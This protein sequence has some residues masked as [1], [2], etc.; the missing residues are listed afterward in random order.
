MCRTLLRTLGHR[1]QSLRASGSK[2]VSHHPS[3]PV[4]ILAISGTTQ[5]HRIHSWRLTVHTHCVSLSE[6]L[7]PSSQR[8]V[9]QGTV[10]SQGLCLELHTVSG[11]KEVK[12]SL[13]IVRSGQYCRKSSGAVSVTHG[14]DCSFFAFEARF[15]WGARA[16]L[17]AIVLPQSLK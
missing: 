3:L 2:P 15:H 16:D 7:H 9:V 8:T 4:G 5:A 14:K 6:I 10:R 1:G 12:R 11:T 17:G 13:S